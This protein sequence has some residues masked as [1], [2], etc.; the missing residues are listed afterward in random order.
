MF[1]GDA[2]VQTPLNTNS[3][4]S[5]PYTPLD[6]ALGVQMFQGDVE[7]AGQRLLRDYRQGA[8]GRVCLEVPPS[9]GS[10]ADGGGDGGDDGG[11]E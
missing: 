9:A 7:R 3:L 11:D 8:L 1:Q 4:S 6:Q 5:K 10:S 2:C